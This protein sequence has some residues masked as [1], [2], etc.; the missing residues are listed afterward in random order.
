MVLGMAM[1][2]MALPAMAGDRVDVASKY[3]QAQTVA[4]LEEGLGKADLMI[5]AKP[6]VQAMVSQFG[7]KIGGAQVLLF[8]NP[9]MGGMLL[10]MEPSVG[11]EMPMKFYVFEK[12]GKV[13]V[14]YRPHKALF[15]PY[16]NK[17]LD[18]KA[19]MMD[20][21]L[22]S[23]VEYGALGKELKLMPMGEMK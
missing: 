9:K 7:A 4:R 8:A 21:L 15:A 6:D 5:V 14:S 19:G 18:E 2:L 11:L 3:S 13:L 12:D 17:M 20:M 22:Q 16:K 10:Q 1:A 23:V